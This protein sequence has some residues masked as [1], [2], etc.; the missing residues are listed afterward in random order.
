MDK[1][2]IVYKYNGTLFSHKRN[3]I[4]IHKKTNIMTLLIWEMSIVGK[5]KEKVDWWLSGAVGE[6]E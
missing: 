1:Q 4:L 3:G 5:F 6:K 2:N